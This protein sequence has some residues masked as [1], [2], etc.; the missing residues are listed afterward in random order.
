MAVQKT[1]VKSR[2]YT[3]SMRSSGMA[4]QLSISFLVNCDTAITRAALRNTRRVR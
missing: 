3:T 1:L 4:T 2:L